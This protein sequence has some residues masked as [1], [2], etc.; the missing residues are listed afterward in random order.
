MPTN[1]TKPRYE[2]CWCT[3]FTVSA[4]I[5]YNDTAIDPTKGLAIRL[6][7]RL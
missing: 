5:A 2:Q 1:M 7:P 3:M 6:G 4:E